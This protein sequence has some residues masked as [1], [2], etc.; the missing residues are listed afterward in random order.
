MRR[1]L[2]LDPEYALA[3]AGLADAYSVFAY[4][5]MLPP[6]VCAATAREAAG[7]A[8]AYGPDLAESHN[9]IAQ[10]SLLFD[11]DWAQTERS[12]TRALEI[13]PAYVQAAA[14]HGLFY[15]GFVRGR[16]TDAV[17]RMLA[18]QK[19]EPL[20]AYVA[21][22]VSYAMTDCGRGTEAVRWGETACRLDPTSYLSLWAYQQAL[23]ADAQHAAAIAAA[24][25]ALA[26]GGRA[27]GA[28][29]T[30][31]LTLADSGDVAGARAVQRELEAR[32]ER[33][34]ISP[35]VRAAVAAGLGDSDAALSLAAD[36]LARRDPAL[37][38]FGRSFTAR[39]I[40]ALPEYHR[41][42][43]ALHM[44]RDEVDAPLA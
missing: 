19:A 25:R 27:Q 17:D 11:W 34:W 15:V 3:W 40:Q 30:L 2:E 26:V 22:C 20:S 37:V 7:K 18:L 21:G 36:A 5:G 35:L 38:V 42:L 31:A 13:N 23:N 12:F 43:A 24:D 28:L 8:L 10:V 39:A 4:Y 14:W 32:A 29:A 6:E 33:E 16:R 41:I 1:A 44:P 9:A